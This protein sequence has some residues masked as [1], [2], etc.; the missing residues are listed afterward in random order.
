M[1]R[2]ILQNQYTSQ[3]RNNIESW[4]KY[5]NTFESSLFCQFPSLEIRGPTRATQYSQSLYPTLFHSAVTRMQVANQFHG[6]LSL[7]V[8]SY[9]CV[10]AR[11]CVC[12]CLCV[13]LCVN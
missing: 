12:V 8:P 3:N 6:N 9:V 2:N 5:D 4:S 10:R 11:V 13:C 7:A 1:N